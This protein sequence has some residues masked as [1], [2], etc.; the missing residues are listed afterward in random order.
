MPGVAPP[1]GGRDEPWPC[2]D[3][4]TGMNPSIPADYHEIA[5]WLTGFVRS[6]AKRESSRIE[7]LVDDAGAREGRS[8]GVRLVLGA[9][10]HPPPGSPI[11]FA[12]RDVA[13]GRTRFEWCAALARDVRAAAR[14]LVS[15]AVRPAG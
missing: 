14:V 13:E 12:F 5:R 9:R 6:H 4:G 8:Y 11:E 15:G 1:G 10:S 7:V 3:P 2:R